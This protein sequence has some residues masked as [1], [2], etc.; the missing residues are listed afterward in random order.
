MVSLLIPYHKRVFIT[1]LALVAVMITASLLIIA[2]TV[3]ILSLL[4]FSTSSVPSSMPST[5]SSSPSSSWSPSSLFGSSKSRK[6]RKPKR[7]NPFAKDLIRNPTQVESFQKIPKK[8][9]TFW[10]GDDE[11]PWIIEAMTKGWK[12]FNPDFEVVVMRP[13]NL[14]R[15]VRGPLPKNFGD[16]A[17]TR[18]QRANWIRLNVLTMHGGFWIDASTVLTGGLHGILSRQ[19]QQRTE[20]FA[21]YLDWF[22]QN[23][24][25][26]VLETYFI[27]TIPQGQW[28]SSWFNEYNTVFS[29]WKCKDDYLDYL[30]S[31]YTESGY[32]TIV[33]NI[34]DN[35][36][37][38]LSVAS[39]RTLTT[40]SSLPHF[41]MP[42]TDRAEEVPYRLL[43][44]SGYEDWDYA[45]S[46][47]N[48]S[49][50][51][52]E[53]EG[54]PLSL[55][56]KMRFPTRQALEG[57]L[58]NMTLV[59]ER[60]IFSRYVLK[61]AEGDKAEWVR[62]LVVPDADSLDAE[63]EKEIV[64]AASDAMGAAMA[65]TAV[66]SEGGGRV[67]ALT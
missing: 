50:A 16:P 7:N 29:N 31:L 58:W 35:S 39:Q 18:Q 21:F 17:T 32:E 4:P 44:A 56:Y 55:I 13:R 59:D 64:K 40:L 66:S 37:L 11:L 26:P 47:M 43:E 8:I 53:A 25:I 23:P 15:Y 27:A 14:K 63:K 45:N 62:K 6:Q 61:F 49:E 2:N 22:T 28:I 41:T 10:D 33:Q 3:S 38:K 48:A 36:Y 57:L 52:R 9:W 60:S 1:R 5:S 65:S 24:K 19:R 12:H 30:Q 51:I 46:L 20:A 67:I 34:N 54:T 42:D